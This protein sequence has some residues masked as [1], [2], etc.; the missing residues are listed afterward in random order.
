[1]RKWGERYRDKDGQLV[2]HFPIHVGQRDILASPARYNAIIAGTGGGKTAAGALWLMLEIA[3]KPDGIFL[4]VTPSY[5]VRDRATLRVWKETVEGT[6]FEGVYI[7]AAS[8][9]R[10]PTGGKI[11]FGTADNPESIQGVVADAAWVDEGGLISRNAWLTVKQ[12]VSFRRGRVLV[13]TTPYDFG[14][15]YKDFYAKHK[16]GDKNYYVRQF[17]STLNPTYSQDE[18]RE[19]EAENSAHEFRMT[20]CGEFCR[21]AGLVY[22]DMESACVVDVTAIPA[23]R[24]VGGLDWGFADPFVGLAGVLDSDDCLWVIFERYIR[25]KTLDVHASNLP[26]EPQYYADSAQPESIKALRKLGFRVKPAF[27]GAGSIAHGINLVHQRIK[28]G[29]LKI[30][31]IKGVSACPMLL[32]EAENYRYST[33]QNDEVKGDGDMVGDDH[34]LDALRYLVMSIDRNRRMELSD[35]E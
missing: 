18:F 26:K 7:S 12:R 6:D 24:F 23:G 4:V 16:A 9:Y 10:L 30:A 5:K 25:R 29:K 8:E 17:P 34:A 14:W 11:Y 2:K 20:Y 33:N 15:L 28:R 19:K 35:D 22:P 31:K 27:K 13:T 3:K 21:A 1:M 32:L